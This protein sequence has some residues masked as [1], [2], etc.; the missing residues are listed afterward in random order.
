VPRE[1]EISVKEI[2]RRLV[3]KALDLLAKLDIKGVR[4]RSDEFIG[5]STKQGGVG[6]SFAL[7]LAGAKAGVWVHR[8][9]GKSGDCV[10]LIEWKLGYSKRDAVAYAKD[11]LG[12]A[13]GVDLPPETPRPAAARPP[14][15]DESRR[16]RALAIWRHAKP[17]AG[18]LAE[19]YCRA[20]G[21]TGPIFPSIRY[22]PALRHPETGAGVQ[23]PALVAGVC[24]LECKVTGIWRI[25]LERSGAGK[26]LAVKKAKLGL[27]NVRGCAVRL[28]PLAP[29]LYVSEGIETG[30]SLA[31]QFPTV[32]VWAALSTSGIRGLVL[33]AEIR[34]VVVCGDRDAAKPNG[35]TPGQDAAEAAVARFRAE[36]RR[37]AIMLPGIVGRDFND[38]FGKGAT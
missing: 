37:A 35:K 30:L 9:E 34:E 29:L 38:V 22:H 5:L 36:G 19:R 6:D 1:P 27:G 28:S 32:A 3:P 4:D 23:W 16:R 26:L 17:V 24:D 21:V 8:A 15:D 25:Y 10:D 31:Q 11:F 14:E 18:T 33:P 2:S 20:R 12:I 13:A 7:C